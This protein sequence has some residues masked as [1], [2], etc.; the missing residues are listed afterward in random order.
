MSTAQLSPC[1]WVTGAHG[2]I[3]RHLCR[4]L[5][6]RGF[7][8]AGL[9]HG[10]WPAAEAERSG[11]CFWLNGE[12]SVSNLATMMQQTGLPQVIYHL[13]GGSS[14]GA[15]LAQPR[16]DFSRTVN[17]TVEL[18]EWVRQHASGTRLVAVSS[19]A[20]YGA[21]HDGPIAE[22]AALHPFSPYGYHKLMMEQ[23]FRSYGENFGTRAIVA[24]LFSVYGAGL[25]KQL[26]WDLCSKLRAGNG[27]VQLGGTGKELRDW[28]HVTDVATILAELMDQA[29]EAVPVC[30]IGSGTGVAVDMIASTVLA[31]WQK[32]KGARATLSFS[33]QSRTGDPFSLVADDREMR[34]MGL[35][36]HRDL[37]AGLQDYVDWFVAQDQA[38]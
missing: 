8:V 31:H 11:L 4:E 17:S 23:L 20:V 22:S 28:V 9:G 38:S 30:N 19:A 36:C 1:I 3:G 29:V 24:R 10:A 14:V 7:R 34:R 18:L 26:L 32:R 2:F 6:D 33:G 25:K 12:I 15:A 35:Q 21:G 5:A 37:V 27:Q 16:E 13:A